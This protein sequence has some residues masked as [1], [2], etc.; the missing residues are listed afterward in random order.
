MIPWSD[1]PS[2]K[3]CKAAPTEQIKTKFCGAKIPEDAIL[4]TAC[5]RQV[6]EMRS[7]APQNTPNIVITNT[8]LVGVTVN[9]RK[10]KDKWIALIL[11]I[12]FD[13]FGAH[14]IYECKTDMGIVY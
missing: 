6:E 9:Q 2:C 12:L 14:K 4:C 7:A 10:E 5:G 8:N 1:N 3:S 13:Y 11:C